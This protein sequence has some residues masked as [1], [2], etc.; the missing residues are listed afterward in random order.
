MRNILPGSP[1]ERNLIS[2]F[3]IDGVDTSIPFHKAVL[4]NKGFIKGEITTSFIDKYNIM[5]EV[6]KYSRKKALS[7]EEKAII[8]STVVSEYMKKKK[9]NDRNS[10]WV[11]T[12]RQEACFQDV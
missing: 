7:K 9:Y 6:K 10:A 3:I 11:R 8:I 1:L 4:N 2:L 5:D 12:A